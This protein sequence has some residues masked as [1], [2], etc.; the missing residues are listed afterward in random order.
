MAP[1]SATCAEKL[2]VLVTARSAANGLS[3]M[4]WVG[5]MTRCITT[6]ALMTSGSYWTEMQAKIRRGK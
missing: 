3:V 5:R 4:L 1:L 6:N 2:C